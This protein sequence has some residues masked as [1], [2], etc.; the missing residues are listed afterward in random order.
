MIS[1]MWELPCTMVWHAVEL[2]GAGIGAAPYGIPVP[3]TKVLHL[4]ILRLVESTQKG[5]QMDAVGTWMG[6]GIR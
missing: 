6:R 4:P 5:I 2:A 3:M 1:A